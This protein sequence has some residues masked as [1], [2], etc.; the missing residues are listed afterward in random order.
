[1]KT[2]LK[3]RKRP[4]SRLLVL[5]KN[6][7]VLLFRFQFNDGAL[8]GEDF[9]ATPGGAIEDGET[10]AQ[11]ARRELKEETGIDRDAGKQIAQRDVVFQTPAGEYVQ[12]DERYFLIRVDGKT[13]CKSG[14]SSLE[15]KYMKDH[16]WWSLFELKATSQTVFPENLIPL[17]EKIIDD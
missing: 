12:A 9:W 6:N 2:E 13:I 5:D 3:M 8:A 16:K 11:A 4:S 7:C 10:Y 15:E 17:I 14:H 1:M